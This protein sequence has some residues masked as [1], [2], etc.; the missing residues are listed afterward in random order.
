MKRFIAKILIAVVAFSAVMVPM[1]FCQAYT[2]FQKINGKAYYYIKKTGKPAPKGWINHSNGTKRYSYG[3][4]K[5]AV[6]YKKIGKY[7][8]YFNAKGI[9]QKG[10]QTIDGAPHYFKKNG[11]AA[12]KGW[13]NHS[14]GTKRYSFG[15]GGIAI[16]YTKIGKY[17]YFFDNKGIMLKGYLTVDGKP[18]YFYQNGRGCSKKWLTYE[19][20]NKKYC[21]GGGKLA[22]GTVR[23]DGKECFFDETG[24]Y[25]PNCFIETTPGPYEDEITHADKTYKMYC[26]FARNYKGY[27]DYL[28]S[29]GCAATSL[30]SI[31]RAY[32]D[33]C[34][35]WTP[36]DTIKNAE[37]KVAGET[38]FN[39]NYDK[40]LSKQMPITLYG[41][42]KVLDYYDISHLYV[43]S[44]SS[45]K[46]VKKD[47]AAHLKNGYPV[48][49][50][51]SQTNRETGETSS[52]W[53]NSYH[54]MVM[55]GIDNKDNV[56]I[57]N[58]AGSQRLQLVSLDEMI[59]Y[60]WSCT[61]D[62]DGF[63][64]NGKKRC[65]GYIKITQ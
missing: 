5:L 52:K 8:Y 28:A 32:V 45:D 2:G 40:K 39:K 49:F 15:G 48:V 20:G 60:M 44:F 33:G 1:D 34:S 63:Y 23:I 14:N 24:L 29:H 22:T 36:Y 9:M 35:K 55:I 13:I 3:K 18:Y 51:V 11:R 27:N 19:D 58:P 42:S 37:K 30:T 56:L 38:T 41:I 53:T 16:G 57:G 43:Q 21:L 47:I 25:R 64:W 46:T 62:P 61:D 65:G 26:Q 7:Y 54:T 10:F 17:Y 4:G 12:S 6:G 50:I 31:L 59:D